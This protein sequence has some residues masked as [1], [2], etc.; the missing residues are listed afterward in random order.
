M[1]TKGQLKRVFKGIASVMFQKENIFPELSDAAE[2]SNQSTYVVG[3]K[4]SYN[5]KYYVNKT[6]ITTAGA[7]DAS[8]WTEIGSAD[9]SNI[10]LAPD[11]DLPVHIDDLT[12]NEGDATINHYKIFGDDSDWVATATK[13]DFEITLVVPTLHTK[14]LELAYGAD[15]VMAATAKLNSDTYE[16]VGFDMKK[17]EVQGTMIL[18]NEAKDA[19][20]ILSNVVL[21]A[22]LVM[23][24][25]STE[26]VGVKFA[27]TLE[28]N[29]G[30]DVLFLRKKK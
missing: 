27:G 26:P 13:G 3:D 9:L 24:N 2:F 20:L 29:E 23:A 12:L 14:V 25:A 5:G 17:T 16:G 4:V 8:K 15:N 28:A 6:A 11:Y 21:W 19:I 30:P 10:T 18:M 1:L 7:W 22:S